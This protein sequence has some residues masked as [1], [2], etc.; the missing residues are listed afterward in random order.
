MRLENLFDMMLYRLEFVI[1]KDEIE[2]FFGEF[3]STVFLDLV[4]E[5]G[6]NSFFEEEKQV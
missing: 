3:G 2:Q 4:G 1:K 5:F 6:K